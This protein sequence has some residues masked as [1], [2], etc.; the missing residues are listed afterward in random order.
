MKHVAWV[1]VDF[2]DLVPTLLRGNAV[3]D[4]LRCPKGKARDA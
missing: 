2:P 3:F 1:L 4:A